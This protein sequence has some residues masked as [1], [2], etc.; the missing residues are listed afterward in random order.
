MSMEESQY[1][2]DFD[3]QPSTDL[4]QENS[5]TSHVSESRLP[6]PLGDQ[7]E[8]KPFSALEDSKKLEA[9]YALL[10]RDDARQPAKGA[11]SIRTSFAP[12]KNSASIVS[13][14]ELV[15][16]TTPSR[17]S[18][19]TSSLSPQKSLAN[20]TNSPSP[21]PLSLSAPKTSDSPTMRVAPMPTFSSTTASSV[22]PTAVAMNP[23]A[24]QT[25]ELTRGNASAAS[26]PSAVSQGISMSVPEFPAKSLSSQPSASTTDQQPKDAAATTNAA[27]GN[28]FLSKSLNISVST[29]KEPTIIETKGANSYKAPISRVQKGS[30]EFALTHKPYLDVGLSFALDNI[31]KITGSQKLP[32]DSISELALSTSI[33]GGGS[34]FS[35]PGTSSLN[36][37]PINTELFERGQAS[38]FH[39]HDGSSTRGIAESKTDGFHAQEHSAKITNAKPYSASGTAAMGMVQTN[40]LSGRKTVTNSGESVVSISQNKTNQTIKQKGMA[41]FV[42][43][44]WTVD[45]VDASKPR[46]HEI[47]Q[48]LVFQAGQSLTLPESG[49]A[50]TAVPQDIQ[51]SL[52]E[53]RRSR[54]LEQ[55]EE[56]APNAAQ[57]LQKKVLTL[58]P[59]KTDHTNRRTQRSRSSGATG[60]LRETLPPSDHRLITECLE[61][62]ATK[63]ELKATLKDQIQKQLLEA[64]QTVLAKLSVDR[65]AEKAKEEKVVEFAEKKLEAYRRIKALQMDKG[66]AVA[67]REEEKEQLRQQMLQEQAEARAAKAAESH[68]LAKER[69]AA[70]V[71]QS[72]ERNRLMEEAVFTKL[73]ESAQTITAKLEI[74]AKA[75]ELKAAEREK[76]IQE[77]TAF[78]AQAERLKT[79]ER[80]MALNDKD[81]NF[82][83]VKAQRE[84]ELEMHTTQKRTRE[85][86]AFFRAE[87]RRQMMDEKRAAEQ[88]LGR[89]RQTAE[90]VL[91][92]TRKQTEQQRSIKLNQLYAEQLKKQL[93]SGE[94]L[95]EP[96]AVTPGPG[97]YFKNVVKEIKPGGGYMASS[98]PEAAISAVPGPGTYEVSAETGH[99][100]S[101]ASGSVPFASRGK[102]DV[103][104]LMLRAAK[105]PGVGQYDVASK[106]NRG[107]SVKLTSKGTTQLDIIIERAKKLPGPGDYTLSQDATHKPHSLEAYL[108]GECDVIA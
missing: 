102:T 79:L 50:L 70:I 44:P 95:T 46:P 105:I 55:I 38:S 71:A 75:N 92:K 104:W 18:T 35:A 68:R 24:A 32:G 94:V 37:L 83:Q 54:H 87:Q 81:Q 40:A 49:N 34:Y 97:E 28:A 42:S 13:A 27:V 88:E 56:L 82:H 4:K 9:A 8:S 14:S 30:I 67:A 101:G 107:R 17:G 10:E 80:A 91:A 73:A 23:R 26:L 60:S 62:A 66:S 98:R 6:I 100:A 85:L 41:G 58:T 96:L 31:G 90:A 21:A 2:L 48:A 53:Q 11:P 61:L 99:G 52:D 45:A 63:A 84:Q 16:P 78:A 103:D 74:Q 43:E 76:R 3:D 20:M 29:I 5:L 19:Q 69:K 51:E 77:K 89:I 12:T 22:A 7:M 15:E 106:S 57:L 36:K 1:S 93:A 47:A 33:V 64:R 39:R 25:S 59:L 65:Q 108:L 86:T 72:K